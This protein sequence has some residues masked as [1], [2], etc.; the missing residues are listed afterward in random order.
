MLK[1]AGH[2]AASLLLAVLPGAGSTGLERLGDVLQIALPA[3]AGLTAV[4]LRD[5]PGVWQFS[6]LM[7]TSQGATHLLKHTLQTRRPDG[8][9]NGFPSAHTSSAFAGA[10]FVAMR[11]GNRYAWPLYAAAAATGY[12]RMTSE[13]HSFV[14]V[15]GGASLSLLCSWA[16]VRRRQRSG[17]YKQADEAG[18]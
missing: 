16:L 11:Y 8:G 13:K 10:A 5:W 6:A 12:S 3:G 17:T 7:V 2:F 15:A 9:R 18:D 1:S 4:V 14:D